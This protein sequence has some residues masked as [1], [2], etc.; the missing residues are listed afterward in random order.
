MTDTPAHIHAWREELGAW[1]LA[2]KNVVFPI[3]CHVCDARLLT[4]DN[5]YFC[6]TCWELSPKIARPYC[7]VCGRP[8]P[9]AAGYSLETVYPCGACLA[10]KAAE[11]PYRCIR[12]A[13]VYDGAVAEAVKLLKFHRKTRLARPLAELMKTF[14]QQELPCDDYDCLVPV[15]LHKVRERERGFNQSRLLA[16][17]L[18]EVFPD[19][20]VDESLW[21]IRPT[22][23]QSL[24]HDDKA[25]R[26]NVRGAFAVRG[27]GLA[28]A[29]VLLIDDVITTGGT[30]GECAAALTRAGAKTV[31]VFAAALAV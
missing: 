22:R 13:V 5:G 8:H 14:A 31:D 7:S 11:R 18:L 28:G 17:E 12:G 10:A 23:V 30:I 6:P 4:D 20:R 2:F 15:P 16:Q 24:L 19:A 26:A 21:R 27:D 3:F 9:V 1:W 29:T 25:R